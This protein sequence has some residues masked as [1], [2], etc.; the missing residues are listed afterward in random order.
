MHVSASRQKEKPLTAR[1]GEN[2]ESRAEKQ[3]KARC[4][5]ET[6][7]HHRCLRDE[8]GGARATGVGVRHKGPSR[9]MGWDRAAS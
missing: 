4:P 3:H 2:Q 1:D 6:A 9:V 8:L 5:W 7:A